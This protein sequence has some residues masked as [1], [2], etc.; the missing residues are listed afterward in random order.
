M[1]GIFGYAGN[2]KV[3]GNVVWEGL[4]RLEYRGYDSWGV[5]VAAPGGIRIKKR[6][7]KIGR[8]KVEDLPGSV[9]GLGHTRWATHGGVSEVNSHPQR[10]CSGKLAVVH[11]GI[12]ENYEEL[13]KV[14]LKKGHKFV[15]QTDTEVFAHLIEEYKGKDGLTAAVRKGFLEIRGLNAVAV[16]DGEK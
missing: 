8:S 16:M 14:L 7:G 15:S 13:K 10:D 11:N 9:L 6:V 5:A 1:C 4:K 2:R 3:A 12:I